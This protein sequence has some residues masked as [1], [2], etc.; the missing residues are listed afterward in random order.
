M[1][2]SVTRQVLDYFEQTREA[3]S[4]TE[5]ARHLQ[6]APGV[7][8]GI[9]DYWVRK[10]ELREVTVDSSLCHTC[11]VHKACPFIV[12]LPHYYERVGIDSAPTLCRPRE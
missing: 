11:S 7:L 8:Q 3:V 6:I 9:L 10:G 1:T 12:T 4:L 2:T 5:L